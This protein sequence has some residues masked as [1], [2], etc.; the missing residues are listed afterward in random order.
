MGRAAVGG[1][2]R[3]YVLHLHFDAFHVDLDG[4]A[5]GKDQGGGARWRVASPRT[6]WRAD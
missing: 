4:A 3:A 6:K 1:P 5:I 2:D